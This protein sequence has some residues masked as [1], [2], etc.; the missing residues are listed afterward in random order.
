M[1]LAPSVTTPTQ[2][3]ADHQEHRGRQLR[4]GNATMT[5][6]SHPKTVGPNTVQNTSQ[7]VTHPGWFDTVAMQRIQRRR[8]QHRQP[9]PLLH[10]ADPYQPRTP[11]RPLRSRRDEPKARC[12]V[13][14]IALPLVTRRAVSSIRRG[15][16]L[17]RQN[18]DSDASTG[19]FNLTAL[20][21]GHGRVS[22]QVV[23]R[24]GK[25]PERSACPGR[26]RGDTSTSPN[27]CR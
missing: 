7:N 11:R 26:G 16:P 13:T 18:P 27:M 3:D 15:S 14:P 6:T 22:A 8:V 25:L 10:I 24:R 5:N 9:V 12:G 1:T 23:W 4:R 19:A 17:L 2:P 21:C 20:W